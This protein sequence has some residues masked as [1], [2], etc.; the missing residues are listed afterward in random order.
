[1]LLSRRRRYKILADDGEFVQSIL[2]I[3]RLCIKEAKID[4]KRKIS[5]LNM[6]FKRG[7]LDRDTADCL[8]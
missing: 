4:A 1:M 3:E 8:M 2:L 7:K 6:R 5:V